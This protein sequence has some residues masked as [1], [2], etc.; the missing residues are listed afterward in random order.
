MFSCGGDEWR[1]G[2]SGVRFVFTPKGRLIEA[3]I[4]IIAHRGLF[5]RCR[6]M[7]HRRRRGPGHDQRPNHRDALLRSLH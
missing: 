3:L 2:L 4:E 7:V 1:H 6:A 5:R